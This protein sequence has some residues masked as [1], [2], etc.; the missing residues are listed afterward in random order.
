MVKDWGKN[1]RIYLEI[2][3]GVVHDPYSGCRVNIGV[4]LKPNSLSAKQLPF[5]IHVHI[6]AGQQCC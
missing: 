2:D 3:F 1:G 6:S 4:L 5:L